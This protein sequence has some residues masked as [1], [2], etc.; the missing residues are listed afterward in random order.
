MTL[1]NMARNPNVV[2]AHR[3]CA[4]CDELTRGVAPQTSRRAKV[5]VSIPQL[6]TA[7]Q[8]PPGVRLA[9]MFVT[10]DPQALHVVIEGADLDEVPLTVE[11][12]IARL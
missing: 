3:D 5:V 12:P 9:R 2:A 6:A 8:L 4:T 1:R 10:D 7:L 11:T